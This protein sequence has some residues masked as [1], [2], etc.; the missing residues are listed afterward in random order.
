MAG[1][2]NKVILMGNLTRDIE[3]RH[4][5]GNQAVANVGIAVN[6]KWKTETGEQREEV[7]FVDCE[8]W[9]RTAEVM[10][11][12]LSKGRPVFIEG[13]LRLDTWQ[14]KTTNENRSKLKVVVDTFQFVDSR[15]DGGGGGGAGS[16]EGGSQRRSSGGGGGGGGRSQPAQAQPMGDDDIPF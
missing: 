6:R 5:S 16:G 15:Q 9:G 3:L 4:T 1:S 8:A 2:F 11:Q 7:T 10:S 14:D 13:R 12:Y